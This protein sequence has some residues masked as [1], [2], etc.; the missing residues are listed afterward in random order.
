MVRE[1]E[2]QPFSILHIDGVYVLGQLLEIEGVIGLKVLAQC[3][4]E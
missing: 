3:V 2:W 4:T 1:G